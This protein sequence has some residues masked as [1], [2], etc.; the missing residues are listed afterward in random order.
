MTITRRQALLVAT[1][2]LTVGASGFHFAS[3]AKLRGSLLSA[4]ENTRGE[5]FIGALDLATSRIVGAPIPLRAHGCDIDPRDPDRVVFFAR[6]PGTEGFEW[7]LDTQQA[8]HVF[9]TP[10]GRHLAGHGLFSRDGAWLFVPEHDYEQAHGVISVRDTRT[11]AIAE[12]L[13]S[14]GLDPHELVW[15]GDELLVANGGI[16]THPRSFRQK[17]NIATMDPCLCRLDART[18]ACLEQLRLPDHL[19]SIRHLSVANADQA[20]AGLQYEGDPQHA[21]GIVAMY[22][23]Q[24]GFELL[25]MPTAQLQRSNGY[26]ASVLAD[27]TRNR[28]YAACPRGAGVAAW[29]LDTAAFVGVIDALE[30]YGLAQAHE[31][32]PLVSQRDGT[33][34]RV[35]GDT[36]HAVAPSNRIRWDDHWRFHEH[37]VTVV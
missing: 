6:R 1:G 3:R 12:E 10:A 16:M 18:G 4:Y 35:N 19:L 9:T 8:R 33:V 2:L 37:A 13:F 20:I 7:R 25:P 32:T 5:Q 17:L 14:G 28:A 11:F 23:R 30:T 27:A 36:A 31:G 15:L 26:V 29:R 21:P 34:L 22:R 24:R